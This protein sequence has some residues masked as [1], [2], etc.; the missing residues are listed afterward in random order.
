MTLENLSF[1]VVGHVDHGKSTLIGRLLYDTNSLAPDTMEEV[2]RLSRDSDGM[3]EFAFVMDHLEE[4]RT[5]RITIDTAQIV[6]KTAKRKYT[7]IDA[8]GHKQFLKNMITGS[9]QAQAA[10]LLVD[11]QRGL[12]EQTRRHAFM[13]SLLGVKQI[14]LAINKMDLVDYSK[15]HFEEVKQKTAAYL[16]K[17]DVEV[18]GEMT[19]PI[20]ARFGDNVAHSGSNLTWFEGPTFLQALDRFRPAPSVEERVLRFPVQD[21]YEIDGEKVL[22][23]RVASGTVRSGQQVLFQPCDRSAV[24]DYIKKF[25]EKLD[26]A[27][28]GESVGLVL[29]DGEVAG[30][31]KRG[32]VACPAEDPPHVSDTIRAVVFWMNRQPLLKGETLDFKCA[33]QQVPCRVEAII[34]RLNSSSLELI[35]EDANELQETEVAKFTLKMDDH[36]ATDPFEK[37][38]EMGRFVLMRDNDIVAGGVLH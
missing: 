19:V 10:V 12:Q 17:L 38:A 31:L 2:R 13:L 14:M 23:G 8:P 1:V 35:A 9:T 21:V 26:S 30:N 18:G 11:A 6:F 37:V 15:R 29:K 25:N 27:V 7:I 3:P 32:Q 20:S 33:T 28:A 16:H 4:E 5:N 36:V 22:A 34:D 24:V